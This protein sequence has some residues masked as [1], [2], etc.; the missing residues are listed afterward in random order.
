V[1]PVKAAVYRLPPP[2]HESK[3]EPTR[4]RREEAVE[5][6]R[7]LQRREKEHKPVVDVPRPHIGFWSTGVVEESAAAKKREEA[8]TKL[9][10]LQNKERD[11]MPL[12]ISLD[13][14]WKQ[15]LSK[16]QQEKANRSVAKT[17][18]ES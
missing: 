17:M 15:N 13:D 12:T 5:R 10:E 4:K 14:Q 16:S 11:H 7:E 6:L 1:R 9:R 3:K 2:G 8:V 18:L